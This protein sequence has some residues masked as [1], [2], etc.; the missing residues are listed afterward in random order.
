LK[1]GFLGGLPEQLRDLVAVLETDGS[2]ETRESVAHSLKRISAT[3][4]SLA[5]SGIAR[6]ASRLAMR[7]A[8]TS[9]LSFRPLL[10]ELRSGIGPRPF[11]PVAFVGTPKQLQSIDQQDDHVCE[12][13]ML[14]ETVDELRD[15]FTVDWPQAIVLPAALG[16][17]VVGLAGEFDCPI[18]LYGPS[19]DLA[20]RRLATRVGADGYIADPIALPELL[21][22]IRFAASR[23][24]EKPSVALIGPPDWAEVQAEACRGRGMQVVTPGAYEAVAA[25]LHG[26]YPAAVVL[27]P[28]N[29]ARTREAIAVMRQH[30]GRTHIALLAIGTP[31]EL[32]TTGVDDILSVDDDL[33]ERLLARLE[34]FRDHRRDRDEL[35][36]VLNRAGALEALQRS[37]ARTS[38]G[39]GPVTAALVYVHGLAEATVEHGREAANACRR[40][41]AA[42]LD[43]GLRRVDL[44]GY[45][46]EDVFLVVLVDCPLDAARRRLDELREAFETRV[47]ADRRLRQVRLSIGTAS[48]DRGVA[49]LM[50]RALADLDAKRGG[51]RGGGSR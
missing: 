3:A 48:T 21:A 17:E 49:G 42:A 22:H 15:A 44:V 28:G 51:T 1:S 16:T 36:Q 39:D 26:V 7:A 38:R 23:P 47:H 34:R 37:V 46:G 43:R 18:Y 31:A 27:G 45:L 6:E 33:P 2:P 41:L 29:E 13:V 35:T 20:A 32:G 40:H 11:A 25:T 4:E 50:P 5:L 9:K 19:R 8:Q 12:P 14:T 30:I 10:E 24:T